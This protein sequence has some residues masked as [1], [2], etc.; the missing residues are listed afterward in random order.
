M[1]YRNVRVH[2]IS[3]QRYRC[4]VNGGNNKT[5]DYLM[6]IA[7][8]ITQFDIPI[9]SLELFIKV[10]VHLSVRLTHERAYLHSLVS[11]DE[12]SV[13]D[14]RSNFLGTIRTQTFRLSM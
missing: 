10:E 14:V 13:I 3:V 8:R 11:P 4:E 2:R 1:F 12:M 7:A 9:E 5:K 6:F